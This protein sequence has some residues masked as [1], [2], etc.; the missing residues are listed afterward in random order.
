LAA[1]HGLLKAHG[2]NVTVRS[3]W[4][5]GT[6]F[7]LRFAAHSPQAK[8]P[9]TTGLAS[10]RETSPGLPM[11][12][13]LAEDEIEVRSSMVEA[14]EGQGYDVVT[15]AT[16]PEALAAL[17]AERFDL[18]ITDLLM[19]E[20]DGM[21]LVAAAARLPS[22]PPVLVITGKASESLEHQLWAAGASRWMA[23][24]FGLAELLSAVAELSCHP[25]RSRG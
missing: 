13:L 10:Q 16:V 19:P 12:V 23:K 24:P 25:D 22:R 1:S 7:E 11:R 17:R 5:Q 8:E 15:A 6:T 2:A 9:A 21:E 18:V 20:G 4:G 3:E 14:L